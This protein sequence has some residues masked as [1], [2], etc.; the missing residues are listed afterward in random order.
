MSHKLALA[1]VVIGGAILGKLAQLQA[2]VLDLHHHFEEVSDEQ[3]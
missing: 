2:D 3:G 1:L